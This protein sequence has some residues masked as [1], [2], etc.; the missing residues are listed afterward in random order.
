MVQVAAYLNSNVRQ[1]GKMSRIV[2]CPV[3]PFN[4]GF[5]REELRR[6]ESFPR[7][8]ADGRTGTGHRGKQIRTSWRDYRHGPCPYRLCH[9]VGLARRPVQGERRLIRSACD[10][11]ACA[12]GSSSNRPR[13]SYRGTRPDT[14][15][16]AERFKTRRLAAPFR[17]ESAH[18]GG[19]RN[20]SGGV[21]LDKRSG[22]CRSR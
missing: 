8:T 4:R 5:T 17:G 15:Q 22:R 6:V 9:N 12:R 2:P 14:D 7:L 11:P 20:G 21:H 13:R 19:Y 1:A 10:Y 16:Q 18:D 3:L